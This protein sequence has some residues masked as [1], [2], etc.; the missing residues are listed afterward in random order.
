MTGFNNRWDHEGETADESREGKDRGIHSHP[1]A[2]E[3]R[4]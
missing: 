2:L 1:H 4:C 3:E